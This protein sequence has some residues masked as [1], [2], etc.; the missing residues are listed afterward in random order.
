MGFIWA[1]ASVVIA[2]SSNDTATNSGAQ[3]GVTLSSLGGA[4]LIGVAGSRRLTNEIDKTI[5]KSATV[6]ATHSRA[7]T[8]D[9]KDRV[10]SLANTMDLASSPSQILRLA[11]N[12]PKANIGIGNN[13]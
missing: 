7:S 11:D 5:L 4:V 13:S 6:V 10:Q 8:T 3:A 9:E 2:G 1:L 12:L